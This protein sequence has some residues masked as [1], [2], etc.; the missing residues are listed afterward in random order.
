MVDNTCDVGSDCSFTYNIQA[1]SPQLSSMSTNIINTGTITLTGTNL[2]I[3][4]PQVIL[5]NLDTNLVSI[6]VPSTSSAT[7]L[8][9][10]VPK[11]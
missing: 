2:N 6:V 8:T 11:V 7:S 1:S 3:G 5:T 4:T 9:F 10:T